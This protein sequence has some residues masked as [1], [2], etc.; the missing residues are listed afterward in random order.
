[1]FSPATRK[2]IIS[3]YFFYYERNRLW[4]FQKHIVLA[5]S[6]IFVNQILLGIQQNYFLGSCSSTITDTFSNHIN[7]NH[8]LGSC[9]FTIRDNLSSP[10]PTFILTCAKRQYLQ[11]QPHKPLPRFMLISDKRQCFQ[12]EQHTLPLAVL[13]CTHLRPRLSSSPLA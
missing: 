9:C 10:N 1:M 11:P 6:Y 5:K 12:S 3:F 7:T 4:L 13:L 2:Q 8:L